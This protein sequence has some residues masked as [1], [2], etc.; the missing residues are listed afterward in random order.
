MTIFGFNY[1][2]LNRHQIS[3]KECLEALADPDKIEIEQSESEDGNPRSM[4]LGKTNSERLIEVGVE[5]MEEMDWIYHAN[6]VK[7]KYKAFYEWSR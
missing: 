7:A 4:W 1:E 6:K 3:D 5:Y 2:S